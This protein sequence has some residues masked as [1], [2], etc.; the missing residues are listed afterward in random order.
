MR[1][2]PWPDSVEVLDPPA[3]ELLTN[4]RTLRFLNP[5]LRDA[6]TLTSAAAAIHRPASS[7]AYWVPRFVRLGLI[8]HLGNET[9][10][11]APMP[12]YRAAA[13]RLTVPFARLP[14]DRRVALL[15]TG[16]RRLLDRFLDGV[17]EEMERSGDFVL[18]FSPSGETGAAIQL[19][20]RPGHERGR[21][22][23][24]GWAVF[25]L[26]EEDAIQLGRDIEALIERYSLKS[27]PRKFI[28]HGGVAPEPRHRWR[29]A[30]DT[31]FG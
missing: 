11:G 8:V 17:D 5:F 1:D 10:A 28:V 22:F 24:D 14:F 26:T 4:V 30:K 2:Q 3:V 27:G 13:R 12:V 15:D 18:E 7:M 29:S 19:R 21:E 23:T 20:D 25:E 31:A 9:R 6:H 16:R